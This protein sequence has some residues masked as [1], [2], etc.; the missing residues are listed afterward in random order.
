MGYGKP[1]ALENDPDAL[2]KLPATSESYED[3]ALQPV[4][5]PNITID[6]DGNGGTRLAVQVSVGWRMVCV[7]LTD[8]GNQDSRLKCWG[9]EKTSYDQETDVL[10][11]VSRLGYDFYDDDGL[12]TTDIFQALAD[13]L[14]TYDSDIFTFYAFKP[15]SIS[16]FL[17][18][19]LIA[20]QVSVGREHACV[21]TRYEN[22]A[23]NPYVSHL[24]CWGSK[25][26]GQLG[27]PSW[28]SG[29]PLGFI[30]SPVEYVDL[31]MYIVANYVTCGD[32]FSCVILSNHK[33]KCFGVN[34]YG[35]LGIGPG[36]VTGDKIIG[37]DPGEMG[38]NLPYVDMGDNHRV[39]HVSTSSARTCAVYE[40]IL[41]YGAYDAPV[42]ASG[43]KCWGNGGGS[44]G[45]GDYD[46]GLFVREFTTLFI[47]EILTVSAGIETEPR[48]NC[49]GGIAADGNAWHY[50]TRPPLNIDVYLGEGQ[51]AKEVQM[52]YNHVCAITRTNDIVCNGKY[53]LTSQL[54]LPETCGLE[55]LTEEQTNIFYGR[56]VDTG[57]C[58]SAHFG[59][60]CTQP[61][62]GVNIFGIPWYVSTLCAPNYYFFHTV[63]NIIILF[64]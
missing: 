14:V 22:G 15:L 8:A 3:E 29:S 32:R 59:D 7:I 39:I 11:N 55:R 5:P 31:G 24:H 43:L 48:L 20:M 60:S 30:D 53:A 54:G 38:D 18:V 35:Q 1:S 28:Q 12:P 2:R 46:I 57:N 19:G 33:L 63:I 61:C 36:Y 6:L 25:M 9:T 45:S 16:V 26:H 41:D 40:R 13:E 23:E 21:V 10:D 44:G 4:I 62:N 17:G 47:N 52:S 27:V 64:C 37:D 56:A 50:C 42:D 58:D 34:Y 51:W 49:D